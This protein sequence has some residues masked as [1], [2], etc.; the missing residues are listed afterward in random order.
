MVIVLNTKQEIAREMKNED[1]IEDL[2]S[3]T[4]HN[5]FHVVYHLLRARN[6]SIFKIIKS[7]QN[8]WVFLN[9]ALIEITTMFFG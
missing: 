2:P 5:Q 9:N 3:L 7:R 1:P 4:G 6:T 8:Q